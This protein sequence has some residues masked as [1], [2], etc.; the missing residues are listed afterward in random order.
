MNRIAS[1]LLTVLFFSCPFCF[2]FGYSCYFFAWM[3][4]WKE[5][6]IC[7]FFLLQ[8]FRIQLTRIVEKPQI[9]VVTRLMIDHFRWS[10][11]EEWLHRREVLVLPLLML[12][13]VPNVQIKYLVLVFGRHV[14]S[15][16]PVL[17]KCM[18]YLR[19]IWKLPQ[20]FCR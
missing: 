12:L 10:H 17:E 5:I 6:V 18:S 9:V 16:D 4:Q 1:I 14:S 11:R 2:L 7:D 20:T 8:N 13:L 15:L 19:R 3:N